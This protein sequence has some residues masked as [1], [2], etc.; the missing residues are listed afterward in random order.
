MRAIGSKAAGMQ[1]AD[2]DQD[3][4][5]LLNGTGVWQEYW[6][7][8]GV[9]WWRWGPPWGGGWIGDVH[10]QWDETFGG[11]WV[12]YGP[13]VFD[14][15]LGCWLW[16]D[17]PPWGDAFV[18]CLWW[19]ILIVLMMAGLLSPILLVGVLLRRLCNFYLKCIPTRRSLRL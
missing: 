13:M 11:W 10:R 7:F 3:P 18:S 9:G 6:Y 12:Y 1:P 17:P 5:G 14:H 19:L 16:E 2:P 15:D 4:D 8:D